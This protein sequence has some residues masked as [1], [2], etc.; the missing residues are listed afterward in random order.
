MHNILDE[1]ASIET[2]EDVDR[3]YPVDV[4]AFCGPA[5]NRF[6]YSSSD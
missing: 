4:N 5:Y 1:V 3:D 2:P 6:R